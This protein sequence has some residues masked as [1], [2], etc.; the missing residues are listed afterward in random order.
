MKKIILSAAFA[1]CMFTAHSQDTGIRFGVKAGPNL[2]TLTGDL[3][4]TNVTGGLHVGVLAEVKFN[5]NWGLQPELL[6]SM[7]G[8]QS[9]LY[10]NSDDDD[11]FYESEKLALNYLNLPVVVKY[12]FSGVRGLSVA[13]GPQIG[14]LLSAKYEFNSYD[15]GFDSDDDDV[16]DWF[17]STDFSLTAGAEYEF[18]FKLFVS[19]RGNLG[20]SNI[21]ENDDVKIHNNV[22]QLSAGY[23]F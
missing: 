21:S 2:S 7:Q 4:D 1:M 15:D 20:L 23:R 12:Y 8:A 13:A 11:F 10:Y 16:K 17:K 18:K 3:D 5:A 6:F 19:V 14:F 22:I 9:D